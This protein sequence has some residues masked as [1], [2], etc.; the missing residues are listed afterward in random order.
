MCGLQLKLSKQ[1]LQGKPYIIPTP[2]VFAA[3]NKTTTHDAYSVISSSLS[4]YWNISNANTTTTTTTV[5]IPSWMKDYFKWHHETRSTLTPDRWKDPATRPKLLILQCLQSNRKCGGLADRLKPL[6]L[7]LLG[8]HRTQ[9]LF[10]V[11]WS[12][13]CPLEELFMNVPDQGLLDWRSYRIGGRTWIWTGR[14][15]LGIYSNRLIQNV[16]P[17]LN[18]LKKSTQA[19]VDILSQ[20]QCNGGMAENKPIKM[21]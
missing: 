11:R 17:F 20:P 18:L 3:M 2:N 7:L 1:Q 5:L 13:P 10:F 15:V 16:Q 4:S 6:P 12:R 9:R 14:E 21:V 8:A 19:Q